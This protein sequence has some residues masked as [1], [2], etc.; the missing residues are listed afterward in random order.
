[1]ALRFI[2]QDQVRV[3][4]LGKSNRGAFGDVWTLDKVGP[5]FR[6]AI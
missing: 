4:S 5:P 3:Q 2:D 6:S 1:M